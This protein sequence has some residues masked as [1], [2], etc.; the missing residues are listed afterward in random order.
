[1]GWYGIRELKTIHQQTQ[2]LYSDRLMDKFFLS[3]TATLILDPIVIGSKMLKENDPDSDGEWGCGTN[4]AEWDF[5]LK[6]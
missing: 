5:L 1:V 2:T 6:K 3:I 4:Y